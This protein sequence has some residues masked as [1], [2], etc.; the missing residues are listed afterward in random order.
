MNHSFLILT[1]KPIEHIFYYADLNKDIFFYVHVDKKIDIN[2]IEKE[3]RYGNVV[4]LNDQD[5]INISWAGFS[6]IQ[7]TINLIAYALAHDKQNEYF[8]LISGDD[9]VLHRAPS[10]NNSDIFIE[11]RE[12]K[13]HQYRMRFDTPHADTK[14]Q[15]KL[16]GKALTQFYKKIDKILPT[17]EKFYFGSQWFSIRRKELEILMNSITESDLNFFRKKL[18]PDE[19]FFQFLIIKNKMLDKV[20][21]YGNKRF[22]KFDPNFQRGSSPICLNTDQLSNAQKQNYWFAR[23]VEPQEMQ[24]FYLNLNEM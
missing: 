13:E 21:V 16:L 3:A 15:R 17:Q 24:K 2:K 7:A 5:R 10:W 20:S 8:H 9:V 1:H 22:I 12:S 6:M 4:F 11:C 14:Y 19:H 18:C 23:K